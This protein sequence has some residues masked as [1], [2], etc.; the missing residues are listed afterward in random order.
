[1]H[2]FSWPQLLLGVQL[3]WK[4]NT[5]PWKHRTAYKDCCYVR[6]AVGQHHTPRQSVSESTTWNECA[7]HLTSLAIR[8]QTTRLQEKNSTSTMVP[9]RV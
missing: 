4:P 2:V 1:M 6:T 3:P 7:T 9:F 8:Y 5:S